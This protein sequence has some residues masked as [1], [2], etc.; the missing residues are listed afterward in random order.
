VSLQFRRQ[1]DI[2]SQYSF[3]GRRKFRSVA[4]FATWIRT[5]ILT[6]V[7]A[8]LFRTWILTASCVRWGV[9][10]LWLASPFIIVSLSMRTDIVVV[11]VACI[12][13]PMHIVD[14]VISISIQ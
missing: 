12:A 14:T 11:V 5:W 4:V 2:S 6:A 9:K 13:F 10:K 8:N 7:S 1:S 3:G